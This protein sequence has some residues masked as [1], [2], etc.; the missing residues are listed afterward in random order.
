[1]PNHVID[2]AP[3]PIVG[4]GR[5][6][7]LSRVSDT[8]DIFSV[9]PDGSNLI[10]LS[11]SP[12]DDV[13]PN[14]S[15]DG[16][17]IAF[18]SNRDRYWNIYRMEADRSN[19]VNL[20]HTQGADSGVVWSPDSEHILISSFQFQ[21]RRTVH[22]YLMNRDGSNIADLTPDLETQAYD[23]VW[24][25]DG[26][27]IA[28]TH[29]QGINLMDVNRLLRV[30]LRGMGGFRP[31]W[32]PDGRRI[33][34]ISDHDILIAQELYIYAVNVDGSNPTRLGDTPVAT[35]VRPIWSPDGQRI[36]FVSRDEVNTD[37]FVMNADGTNVV[38]LTHSPSLDT[39]PSWS[40]DSRRIA[41]SS[42]R[43]G[44]SQIYVMDADGSNVVQLTK[45]GSNFAPIWVAG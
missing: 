18:I 22:I 21:S 37:I 26:K 25:P 7:F 9:N 43:S 5:I 30:K 35:I 34:F 8:T 41:F 42:D 28:F 29:D 40:P 27:T 23:P 38:N 14:M 11:N 13:D 12:G 36:A 44:L 1:M 16:K 39:V 6:L 20:T 32:S 19:L 2:A 33:A 24:S 45:S 17:Y 3:T 31:S 10:N 15:P 4:E